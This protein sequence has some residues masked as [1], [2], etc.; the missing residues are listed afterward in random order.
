M[1]EKASGGDEGTAV[2]IDLQS[3]FPYRLAVLAEQ[4]SLAVAQVYAQR[5]D[6][7]RQEWRVLAVLGGTT[8]ASATDIGH[9]TSLDKMQVSRAM[10]NLEAR[11]VIRRSESTDDRRRRL[12]ELT[13]AGRAL[14]REIVPLALARE[15][16]LLAALSPDELT[17]LEF[18][19]D[20]IAAATKT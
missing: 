14:Y 8:E 3:Y 12:V 20:K 1:P 13:K 6:L 4:V 16:T 17:A 19:M 18:M 5:F 2:T 11:G 9:I 7:T 15:A 10:R